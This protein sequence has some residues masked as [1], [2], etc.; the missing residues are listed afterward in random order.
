MA[1]LADIHDTRSLALNA[2]R[3]GGTQQTAFRTE[4]DVASKCERPVHREVHGRSEGSPRE[5]TV[6]PGEA[7]ASNLVSLKVRCRRC[8]A[9]LRYRGAIWRV[10]A[11]AEVRSA[12]RTWMG[13]LTL[14]PGSHHQMLSRARLRWSARGNGDLDRASRDEQFLARHAETSRE[15]TKMVKRM[16]IKHGEPLRMLL[17]TEAHKS[18][19]PH[20]HMLVHQCSKQP[21]RYDDLR[22]LWPWGFSRWKLCEP[23]AAS[24]VCKYLTKSA[25]ARVRAS[26]AYGSGSGTNAKPE[27]ETLFRVGREA[28]VSS[29]TTIAEWKEKGEMPDLHLC[30][31][32]AL[33]ERS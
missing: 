9:C 31:N 28:P 8:P 30:G 23:E 19:L 5:I 12:E 3:N 6:G 4:W 18:G 16:R 13:T 2:L 10:R 17:V 1:R 7:G 20:Y 27:P 25:T 32:G 29:L 26:L 15:L 24:Y 21:L 14:S 11:E 22:G 33:C